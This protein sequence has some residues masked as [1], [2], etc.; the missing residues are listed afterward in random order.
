MIRSAIAFNDPKVTSIV[1]HVESYT[2]QIREEYLSNV[3]IQPG[4]DA[5][6]TTTACQTSNASS[7]KHAKLMP[8]YDV[9]NKGGEHASEALHTGQVCKTNELICSVC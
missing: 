6:S 9:N 2:K 1:H 4:N 3:F 7:G 8:D 5:T